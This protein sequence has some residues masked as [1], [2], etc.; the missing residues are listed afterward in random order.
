MS[1][2]RLISKIGF[3]WRGTRGGK[4]DQ[5]GRPVKRHRRLR[6]PGE[7]GRITKWEKA[8]FIA[9]ILAIGAVIFKISTQERPEGIQIVSP[10]EVTFTPPH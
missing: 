7:R 5:F 2:S 10:E 9:L 4:I 1:F 6:V 3:R 8:I